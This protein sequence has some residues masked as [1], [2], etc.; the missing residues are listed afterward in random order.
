MPSNTIVVGMLSD[1]KATSV[2]SR[3]EPLEWQKTSNA[4][5]VLSQVEPAAIVMALHC[6]S[7][8]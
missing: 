8:K 4:E 2:E 7:Y 6:F 5:K 1:L 3:E